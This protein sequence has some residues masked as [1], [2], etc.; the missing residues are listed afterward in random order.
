[1]IRIKRGLDLPIAGAPK[2]HIEDISPVQSVALLGPD[3]P[4]LRP[5]MAVQVG[6][7]VRLGQTLFGERREA[8]VCYTAPAAGTVRAI[9]RGARRVL[10][11]V[12]IEIDPEA[13]RT[14]AASFPISEP[15]SLSTAEPERLRAILAESGLWTVLRTR[16][17]GKVPAPGSS[18]HSLFINAMDTNPLAADPAVIIGAR[19]EEFRAGL[20]ALCRLAAGRP[21]Y[22]CKAPGMQLPL[23]DAAELRVEEFAGPHPAGLAGTHIHFLDPVGLQK[24]VWTIASPDVIAIGQLLLTG[25]LPTERVVALAGPQVERPRLVR[26]RL[27]ADLEDLCAGQTLAG[28]NRLLSGSVLSG[29]HAEG[30]LAFLGRRHSQVTVLEEGRQ[31]ELFGWLSPGW[32]RHSSMGIYLSRW[33]AKSRKLFFTTSANGS[34]RA[35][36]PTGNFERVM[37]LDILPTHLLRYLVAGDTAMSRQMGCLELEEEDLALCAYVCSGKYEYGPILREHLTRIEKEG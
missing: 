8:K 1:M 30:A 5:A 33:F 27:G 35:M 36:V 29:H 7:R 37:P 17:Y 23:P 22:L 14:Q 34:E 15:E 6:E 13:E 21:V 26:T 4:G 16:P 18:P 24:T 3:Y 19:P 11:S 32:H 20:T 2:Q 28:D 25:C 31:R 10:L 12:V 9:N